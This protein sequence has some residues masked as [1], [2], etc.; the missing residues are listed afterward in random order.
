MKTLLIMRHAKSSWKH[1]ELPDNERPLN[2]RGKKEAPQMAALLVDNEL[3]P[4]RILSST[5]VRA[6]ATVDAII[7]ATGFSEP[8]TFLDSFYMAEPDVYIK[9]VAALPDDIERVLII[10]HNPG[11]EG[12]LQI[13]SRQI[14][15][16]PPAGLVYLALPISHWSDLNDGVEAE[17]V[18]FWKPRDLKEPEKKAE[19]PKKAE[20]KKKKPEE[21]VK[22]KK[23]K[24]AVAKAKEKKKEK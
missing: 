7:S 8:V 24:A 15:S 9:E 16:L 4:Q 13:L 14:E 1:P 21:K 3:I 23:P 10:G 17:L 11:L 6:R 20:D 19:K 22:E 5:A 12:V 2:K 18:N